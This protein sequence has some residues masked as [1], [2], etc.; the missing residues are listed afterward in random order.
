[1][2]QPGRQ[3]TGYLKRLIFQFTWPIKIDCWII[4]YPPDSWIPE[5]QDQV[6]SGNHH[7]LNIVLKRAQTGGHLRVNKDIHRGRVCYF[8]PDLVQH[9]VTKIVHGT[10]VVLSIGWITNDKFKR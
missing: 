4:K 7:R 5:H 9:E 2:W 10:R 1:M 6:E 3:G 8:R